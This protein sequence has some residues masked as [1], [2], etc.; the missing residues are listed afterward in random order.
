MVS[1]T[2]VFDKADRKYVAGETVQCKVQVVVSSKFKAR[3]LS[4]R[5]KGI[6]HTEWTESRSVTE[7]NETR[8]VTDTYTGDEQY[9]K[10]YQYLFGGANSGEQEITP[11]THTYHASFRLPENVP[12]R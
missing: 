4:M 5:F 12:S 9:F 10:S 1:F 6:A 3:S 8:T 7:N 2:F 11:G